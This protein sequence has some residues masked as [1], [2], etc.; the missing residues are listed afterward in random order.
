MINVAIALAIV[1]VVGAMALFAR[2]RQHVD[3]PTQ[4]IFTV[5]AQ[6]DRSD[7][8]PVDTDSAVPEWLIVVFTSS[9]CDVCGDVW[10]KAQIM[11][12]RHVGVHKVDYETQGDLHQKY[13]IDA[14][15]TLVICDED[16][17]VHKHF[18]GPVS[19]THLW[20]AVATVRDPS[21]QPDEGQ[22]QHS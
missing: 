4:K 7:F 6:I 11:A 15:P 16:G 9:A 5:P 10:D 20:A 1:V 14:V 8:N 12:S 13:K 18:L 21:T 19:A 17:V 2:R 3:V 22:C